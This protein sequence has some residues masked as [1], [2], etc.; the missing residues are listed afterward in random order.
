MSVGGEVICRKMNRHLSFLRVGRKS[1][2]VFDQQKAER[3]KLINMRTKVEAFFK[4]PLAFKICYKAKKGLDSLLLAHLHVF[5]HCILHQVLLFNSIGLDLQ[6]S[7][8][9]WMAKKFLHEDHKQILPQIQPPLIGRAYTLPQLSESKS[10]FGYCLDRNPKMF[11]DH[12]SASGENN[13][14]SA[15]VFILFLLK[16]ESTNYFKQAIISFQKFRFERFRWKLVSKRISLIAIIYI[17]LDIKAIFRKIQ[18]K[19]HNYF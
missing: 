19:T 17:N 4:L 15:K 8:K 18:I 16:V 13:D 12:K 1:I 11:I 10:T 5:Q 14:D 9:F 3:N 6:Q 7:M 2:D